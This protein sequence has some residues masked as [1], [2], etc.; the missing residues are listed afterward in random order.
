MNNSLDDD[1]RNKKIEINKIDPTP[2][3][4]KESVHNPPPSTQEMHLVK[5]HILIL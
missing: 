3:A 2:L 1:L 5:I 4:S